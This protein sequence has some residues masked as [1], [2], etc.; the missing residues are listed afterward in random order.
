MPR[1]ETS[2]RS[3]DQIAAYTRER[4]RLAE[5]HTRRDAMEGKIQDAMLHRSRHLEQAVA[6]LDAPGDE[7]PEVD[8]SKPDL[9]ALYREREIL[10]VAAFEQGR[11]TDRALADANRLVAKTFLPEHRRSAKSVID[12]FYALAVVMG[13]HRDFMGNVAG[14]LGLE[15]VLP[16]AGLRTLSDWDLDREQSDASLWLERAREALERD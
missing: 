3:V 5:I 13:E 10:R 14:G 4:D 1:H 15:V 7:V 9:E 8:L 12:A 16:P 11:R 2:P 6:M